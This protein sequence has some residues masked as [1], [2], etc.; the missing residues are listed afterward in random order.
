MICALYIGTSVY[1]SKLF[2]VSNYGRAGGLLTPTPC[3]IQHKR[4]GVVVY[5]INCYSNKGRCD[6]RKNSSIL[7]QMLAKSGI[8]QIYN[9]YFVEQVF[10]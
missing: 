8:M 6:C 3:D 7:L 5:I 10:I 1:R 9:I 4:L 2:D